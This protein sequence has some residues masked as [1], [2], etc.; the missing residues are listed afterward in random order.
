MKVNLEELSKA[1]KFVLLVV[2]FFGAIFITYY[3]YKHFQYSRLPKIP[4]SSLNITEDKDLRKDQP[5]VVFNGAKVKL[6]GEAQIYFSSSKAGRLDSKKATKLAKIFNFK[7]SP[8][9]TGGLLMWSESKRRFLVD[10]SDQTI[11]LAESTTAEKLAPVSEFPSKEKVNS[12]ARE[13]LKQLSFPESAIDFK[14]PTSSFSTGVG[15]GDQR[16]SSEA[17]VKAVDY[18]FKVDNLSVFGVDTKPLTFQIKISKDNKLLGFTAP[19]QP[20]DWD[21]V[22]K[23][24]LKGIG[25]AAEEIAAGGGSIVQITSTITAIK[26]TQGNKQLNQINLIGVDLGYYA[27]VGQGGYYLVPIYIFT[28]KATFKSAEY[29]DIVFYISALPDRFISE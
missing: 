5:K 3:F 13:V 6:R 18:P 17:R 4:V 20:F 11:I 7:G 16:K 12:K 24:P 1:L 27:T 14:K 29:S 26:G 10:L 28:G 8:T 15:V 2:G 23:Y 22:E 19:W 21:L 25:Q 9:K